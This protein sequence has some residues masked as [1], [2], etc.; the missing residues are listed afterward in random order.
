MKRLFLRVM[1]FSTLVAT[2]LLI[3]SARPASAQYAVSNLVSNDNAFTPVNIDPNLVNGWGLAS[4]PNSPW[5]VAD[6]NSSSSTLY[7]SDG[8]DHSVSRPDSLCGKRDGH[9]SV[10]LSWRR[11]SV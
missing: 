9:S 8:Y 10:P 6:Q 11:A 5:W 4:F 2:C 3:L 1:V 7:S